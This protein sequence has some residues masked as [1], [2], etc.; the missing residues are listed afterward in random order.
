MVIDISDLRLDPELQPRVEGVDSA[1]VA[2]LEQ[3]PS[4]WPAIAVVSGKDGYIVVDGFHRVAAAQ[5]LDLAEIAAQVVELPADA[6][7]RGLAF[8]LNALHGKALTLADRKTE[9]ARRLTRGPEASNM[10]LARATD[11]SPTTIQSIRDQLEEAAVIERT[12]QRV[13]T[14]GVAYTPALPARKLGDLQPEGFGDRLDDILGSAIPP[15]E[16]RD[17]RRL[18]HYLER[19]SVALGDVYELDGWLDDATAASACVAV[20]GPERAHSLAEELGAPARVVL[21]VAERLVPGCSL[22]PDEP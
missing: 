3:S 7:L 2:E 11:L 13:S 21:E 16:R 5:N 12:S 14:S 22:D 15:S 9:A 10:E 18:A 19:L 1:H 6:D 17:Q 8:G 4:S 20:L